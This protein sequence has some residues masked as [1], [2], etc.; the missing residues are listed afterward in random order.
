MKIPQAAK[1]PPGVFG[2]GF[3]GGSRDR[4]KVL[5]TTCMMGGGNASSATCGK[6]KRK[7]SF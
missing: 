6:L 5:Y 2:A 4:R 1:P 7:E 3:V